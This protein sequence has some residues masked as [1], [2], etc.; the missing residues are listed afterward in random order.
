MR[1]RGAAGACASNWVESAVICALAA[2]GSTPLAA[3]QRSTAASPPAAP[4]RRRQPSRTDAVVQEGNRQRGLLPAGG[5]RLAVLHRLH[6]HRQHAQHANPYVLQLIMDSLRYWV[7]EMHVDGF[8]FDLASTLARGLHEV[9]R[10]SAFFD[11]IQQDPVV[12]RVKLIAEPWDVG[13]GGYQVGNFPPQWA[14]WNGRYRDSVRDYWRGRRPDAGRDRVPRSPARATCTRRRAGDRT[15]ASTSS[16][17]TTDSRC[18]TSSRYNEKHNEAN[19][20]DNNDG[21]SHNRVLEL[22]R[23]RP[24]RRSG[25][26][27]ASRPPAA[28]PAGDAAAVAGRADAA[29][30]RRDRPHAAAATTT[31]TARTTRSRGTTGNTPTPRCY[32]FTSARSSPCGAATRL[33]AAA[34]LPR[35]QRSTASADHLAGSPRG[36][37][38]DD[39]AGSQHVLKTITVY[40]GG[41][42]IEQGPR[43]E[44]VS[45]TNVLW[46]ING[47]HDANRPWRYARRSRG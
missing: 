32:E 41:G 22:R 31:P 6:G 33:P 35:A 15:P 14:E 2:A 3:H 9:D 29:R 8:R 11:L 42:S 37:E 27:R 16:P 46:L 40:L 34:V 26:Q 20:E 44:A 25:D 43:G 10:L 30:R 24:D 36:D 21:E 45:D 18:A 38:M 47:D 17:R 1:R 5:R 39:D 23:R 19:G 12:S 28:E 13:E 7:T 4:H